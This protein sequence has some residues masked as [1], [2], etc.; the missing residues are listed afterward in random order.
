M[1]DWTRRR[2]LASLGAAFTGASRLEAGPTRSAPAAPAPQAPPAGAGAPP[3][4]LVDYEP[5][6]MLHVRETRVP[7]ARFP[8]IDVHTHPGRR[9]GRTE[10]DFAGTDMEF[11]ATAP[12]LRAAMDRHNVQAMVNLTGGSGEGLRESL[13]RFDE[14][15][16]GRLLTFTEPLWSRFAEPG[17]ARLQ[18]DEIGRAREAGAKGLKILK[19]L[20]L[21]LREQVTTG[22]LVKVDDPRFDPMWE[23]CGALGMPVAI[24]VADP[25]AFFLPVDRFNERYEELQAHPDWSFHGRD[26]PPFREILAARDRV[27]LRHPRTSFIVLHVGNDAEDLGYVGECL[28]RFPNMHVGIAARIAELGRQPYSSRRFFDRYQDRIVFGTDTDG[29]EEAERLWEIYFRFLEAQDEYFAYSPAAVPP[30]GRWRIYGLGLE[31]PVLRKVYHD[32][33][34]RLLG[35]A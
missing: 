18:G 22:P 23:A 25:E 2:W 28:D 24:H 11:S 17:F 34:A 30:Q 7:R 27:L 3:L 10:G 26:F 31:E 9:R 14:Q 33:A 4:A 6:S 32:N 1:N 15:A 8:V 12:E 5:R 21:Y 19:T 35:L 16:P 20:G 29:A 13:R